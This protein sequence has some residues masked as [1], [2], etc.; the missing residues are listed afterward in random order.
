M[1]CCDVRRYPM[2]CHDTLRYAM[3]HYDILRCTTAIEHDMLQ[4]IMD[5]EKNSNAWNTNFYGS[6]AVATEMSSKNFLMVPLR[7][8]SSDNIHGVHKSS[9][10]SLPETS[11][12]CSTPGTAPHWSKPHLLGFDSHNSMGCMGSMTSCVFIDWFY[13]VYNYVM[14][15]VLAQLLKGG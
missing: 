15:L 8:S 1:T 6:I 2:I 3:I 5:V 7:L 10:T 9:K 12:P 11:L 14:K 4:Y 13:Y